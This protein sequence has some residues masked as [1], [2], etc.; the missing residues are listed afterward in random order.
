[1][2]A[3]ILKEIGL[4]LVLEEVSKPSPTSDQVLIR[5]HACG[6]CRTDLHIV[7]GELPP[8]KL[9]LILGHQIVGEIEKIGSDATGY[10]IGDKVGVPWLGQTC[11]K[12]PYCLAGRENLCDNA[13]FTGFS[14]NGGFAEYCVA[15]FRYIF[16]LSF[17][18]ADLNIAPLLC[19]GMIGYRALKMAGRAKKIGFYGFGSSAH[20][21]LQVARAQGKEI[22]AF[23]RPNDTEGQRSALKLGAKW[24]GDSEMMPPE[25]LDAAIIF[26]SVGALIPG[27]LKALCKGGILITAGIHMSDIP[28]FSYN[29]LWGERVIRSVAHLTREDGE[30]FL[31][32]ARNTKVHAEATSYRLEEVN[33]ALD[34]LRQGR[35]SGSA[36]ISILT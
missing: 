3:Q 31:T 4:P 1:M 9:P 14:R 22:Y 26:A 12:C 17:P 30:E 18:V 11:G 35:L 33:M 16:P 36:V 8:P 6:L 5:V 7:D 13:I 15:H 20:L 21:L 32:L 29:L 27:A 24:A 2:R 19:A 10:N 34:D 28:S 23:T 25:P